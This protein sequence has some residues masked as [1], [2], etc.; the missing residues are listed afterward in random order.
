MSFCLSELHFSCDWEG[1]PLPHLA[2]GE[3]LASQAGGVEGR[4]VC[5]LC[6]DLNGD[7]NWPSTSTGFNGS[8]CKCSGIWVEVHGAL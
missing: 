3:G 4:K 1:A 7:L 2:L 5:G 6:K 8:F